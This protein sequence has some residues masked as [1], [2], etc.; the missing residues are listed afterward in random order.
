MRLS[1]ASW[2]CFRYLSGNCSSNHCGNL[3]RKSCSLLSNSRIT[4]GAQCAGNQIIKESAGQK[5]PIQSETHAV[6][7]KGGA[8]RLGTPL[9]GHYFHK[10][11]ARSPPFSIH[12]GIMPRGRTQQLLINGYPKICSK[13]VDVLLISQGSTLRNPGGSQGLGNKLRQIGG[14]IRVPSW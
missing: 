3:W 13:E 14:I 2:Y 8:R 6:F 7:F 5:P 9:L 12:P 11:T 4:C 1:R 10:P